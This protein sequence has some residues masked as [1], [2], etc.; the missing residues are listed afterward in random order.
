MIEV[1]VINKS[2]NPLPAYAHSGDA[3]CDL[4]ADLSSLN[5]ENFKGNNAYLA[6]ETNGD[7]FVAIRPGGTVLIPTG[8]F[9][10]IPEGY[11]VQV[12]PRSGLALKHSITVLN[13]PGTI[14]S[15]YRSEWGVI[16]INHGPELFIVH[17]G[18]RIAQ[19]VLNKVE[20]IK[21]NQV[22]SLDETERKGGFGSTGI[23]VIDSIVAGEPISVNSESPK[24]TA[25]EIL[26]DT[27][28]KSKKYS[29]K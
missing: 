23:D 9:T 12:R 10:A 19:A 24:L 26:E 29:K 3:G 20:Q 5:K 16:L 17:Q 2:N 22:E 14:D 8:L 27:Q 6:T 11:E 4:M 28:S 15:Q 7:Q 25:S 18:D 21:W 1:K 13:T